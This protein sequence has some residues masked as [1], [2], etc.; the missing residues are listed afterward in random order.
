MSEDQK[1][2]Q[3]E[4]GSGGDAWDDIGRQFQTL[5]ESLAKAFRATI[6]NEKNQQR[7]QEMRSGLESIVRNVDQ[8]IQDTAASPEG[9][10]IR[11]EA[12]RA[13]ESLRIA[14]EKAAQE[15]RPH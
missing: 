15:A 7:I 6:E 11:S 2:T 3:G 12:S 1:T 10:Q 13:A 5:G 8:A 14:T 4:T 9:Q